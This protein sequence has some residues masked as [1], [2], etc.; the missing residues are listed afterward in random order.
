MYLR[1]LFLCI[2]FCGIALSIVGC[3]IRSNDD[4]VYSRPSPKENPY[5]PIDEGDFFLAVTVSGGGSRSAVWSAA[6]LKELYRQVKL[7]GN[8]SILD[9]IDYISCVSGGSFSSSYYCL[10]KPEQDTTHTEKYDEFFCRFLADMRSNVQGKIFDEPNEWYRIF[11]SDEHKGI[12]FKNEL[13]EHFLHGRTFDY[14]YKREESGASPTLIINGTEMDSGAK[15]LF[16]TFPPSAFTHR[17]LMGIVDGES[18]GI[19]KSNILYEEAVLGVKFCDDIGLSIGDMEVSRAV[20]AST[21]V[22]LVFGPIVLKDE[23]RSTADKPAYV[24]IND[25]GISDTLGL[26]TVMQLFLDRFNRPKKKS[27]RGGLVLIIDANQHLDPEDS[28][29]FVKGFGPFALVER[30]REII[31]YRGK[32]LAYLTIMLLQQDP[33]YRDIRFVYLSPYMT[34]N[35]RV[36]NIVKKTPIRL[37]IKPEQADNLEYAAKLVVGA[38]KDRILANF[39]GKDV[40][41]EEPAFIE[42]K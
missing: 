3:G 2:L 21:S 1:R 28:I 11:I 33:R 38:A 35:T 29:Y 34:D 37:K 22:P 39:N 31:T 4:L 27:F 7:P 23:V 36:I 41:T 30:S 9:E 15:F 13:D 25:G 18:T 5:V 40:P 20:A 8:R 12:A 26:E 6:V 32:N 14:L 42:Q 10:N 19:M 24:H 16:T 17:N